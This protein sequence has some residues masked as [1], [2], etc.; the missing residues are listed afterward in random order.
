MSHDVL[1]LCVP[2]HQLSDS[3]DRFMRR[4]VALQYGVQIDAG[5]QKYRDDPGRV[6]VR[7]FARALKGGRQLPESRKM[8]MLGKIAEYSNCEIAEITPDK[9]EELANIETRYRCMYVISN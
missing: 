5:T 1:L 8:E 6:R 4:D 9:I 2:C 7:S 3:Y